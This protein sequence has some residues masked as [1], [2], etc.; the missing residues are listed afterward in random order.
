M[1]WLRATCCARSSTARVLNTP[2]G[3]QGD[4]AAQSLLV[5]FHKEVWGGE[6]FFEY[7]RSD[8]RRCDS[9]HRSDRTAVRPVWRWATRASTG[10]DPNGA[11]RLAE[12][13]HGLYRLIP[14]P[15]ANPRR[16]TRAAV[17][18]HRRS[19]Q[20]DHALRTLVAHRDRRVCLDHD[21][22]RRVPFAPRARS[23]AHQGCARGAYGRR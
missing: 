6:K 2:W 4:W 7:P 13:Q 11:A 14:R 21:C 8:Q 10:Q 20:S 19:P 5:T 16:G 3:A 9:L 22:L 12:L 15:A 18:G 1:Y 23:G 17:E